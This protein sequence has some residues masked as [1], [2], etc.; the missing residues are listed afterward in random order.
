M[1]YLLT[2]SFKD[3]LL[4]ILFLFEM[5][6]DK[7]QL[8]VSKKKT[9]TIKSLSKSCSMIIVIVN[10]I[11]LQYKISFIICSGTFIMYLKPFDYSYVSSP[12]ATAQIDSIDVN[13]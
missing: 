6:L 5:N 2:Y 12:F 9:E 11:Y 10:R 7:F 3:M 1:T 4:T 8:K 13:I